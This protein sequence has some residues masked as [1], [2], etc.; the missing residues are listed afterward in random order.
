MSSTAS[1]SIRRTSAAARLRLFAA[2]PRYAIFVIKRV[3][4]GNY[5][6]FGEV[7]TAELE[8]ITVIV[9]A[10]NSGK[11]N[12]LNFVDLIRS[13]A[14]T[15]G[16]YWHRPPTRDRA[17]VVEVD[18]ELPG[19]KGLALYKLRV[20]P[21][22]TVVG[23]GELLELIHIRGNDVYSNSGRGGGGATEHFDN[24]G[25]GYS[26]GRIRAMSIVRGDL[27]M[28]SLQTLGDLLSPV[29]RARHVH[30]RVDAMRAANQ[31]SP[32]TVLDPSGASLAALLAEW[33]FEAPHTFDQFNSMIA[34]C[35]PEMAR[36]SVHC[37]TPGTVR[38]LFEQQDGQAF[39]ATQ[40]SDGVLVFAG[41]IAHALSAP[42]GSL[43]M[44]EEPERGLHPRRLV[45]LVDLLRTLVTER[46]TQFILATHSPALL[47]QFRDE[48]ESVLTFRRSPKG[49][50]IKRLSDF[51]DMADTLSRADPG[52]LL[53]AG[54][55]NEADPPM[56][57]ES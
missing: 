37:V 48:P 15:F 36:V 1:S 39:D 17:L 29:V 11:T 10:N 44:I 16:A 57:S 14:Q 54:M 6:S 27:G 3:R 5:M 31:I 43:M 9:G 24:G 45:E 20:V 55:F 34:R 22:D 4:L 21:I 30:L 25:F 28:G 53:A 50:I 26:P 32:Q 38:L 13:E 18:I 47:N 8:A 33:V 12:F 40:V 42:P 2:W 52:E 23:G 51:P 41:L 49:T 46:Q 19:E 7:Q 56:S 35:L